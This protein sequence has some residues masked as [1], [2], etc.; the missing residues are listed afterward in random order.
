[1]C[2][3]NLGMIDM[4]DAENRQYYLAFALS[5]SKRCAK[6]YLLEATVA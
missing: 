6:A 3:E 2:V 5:L 1:M 4:D